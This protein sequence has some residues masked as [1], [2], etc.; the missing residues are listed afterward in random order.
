MVLAFDIRCYRWIM[1]RCEDSQVRVFF[2]KIRKKGSVDKNE[3]CT[4]TLAQHNDM[5]DEF[6]DR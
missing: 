2:M 5:P 1:K 6:Y 4:S 3:D